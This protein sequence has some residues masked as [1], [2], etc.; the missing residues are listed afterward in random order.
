MA[1]PWFLNRTMTRE[2]HCSWAK[3]TVTVRFL[4]CD[5]RHPIGLISCSEPNCDLKCLGEAAPVEAI[6]AKEEGEAPAR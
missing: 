1:T 4:T 5:G 3:R 6:P 2:F